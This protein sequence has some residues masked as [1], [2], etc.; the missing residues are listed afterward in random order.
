MHSDNCL[1]EECQPLIVSVRTLVEF[2]LR[3]GDLTPGGFQKRDRAQLGTQGHQSVQRSRPEGYESEV[4]IAYRVE[5][6]DLPVEVRGR[7]DGLYASNDPVI[8]EEIKTTTLS[9]ELISEQHNPLHWAQ[10][11]CYAYMVARQ[12]QLSEVRVHLTYYHLDSR[13]EKTFERQYPLAE[14]QSFFFDLITPYLDWLRKVQAWQ[15]RRDRSIQQ[16]E[17]PYAEYRAG[18]RDMAV[19]VYKAVRSHERLYIQSPTGVGKTMAAL[20]PA[21][22]ALGQGLAGKIF[23]LTAKTSGRSVAEKGLDDLRQANLYLR[24]VTLTAKEKICFCPPVTCDPEVCPFAR[25]YFGKVKRALLETADVQAFTRPVIEEIARQYQICPFEFSLDLA[26]WADCVICDYNYAFDPRV[27]LHRFFDNNTEPYIFLVD[28]A[29]NLPDRARSMYSAELDKK[30]V[31]DLQRTLKSQLPV[32]AQ[33]LSAINKIL[34]E[35]RKTCQAQDKPALVEHEPPKELIKAIREFSQTAEDWLVLNQ[36][37]A[38]RQ[39]LIEFY[40]LCSHYLRTA[41]YFDRFYV[42]Y[43]ERQGSSDLKAKIFCLDPAPMLA[44][45]LERSQAAIFFSATLLPM[46]YFTKLLTGA[47]VHPKRTFPSPFPTENVS[48]LIHNG[49]TTK[50]AQRADSYAAIANAIEV[51][52]STHVGN[53]LVFFPSYA[54]LSAVLELLKERLPEKQLLVQDRSMP[55]AER[56][57]FLAQFSAGNHETLIGFAVMGGIFGEGIDL[58]GERLIGAVVV[59]V[60]VPQVCLENDLIKEYF[61]RQNGNGFAYAYQYPGF[62]R[63][64]QATGRVIRTE[65]D[66]GIIVLIDERFSQA[67]YR[68]LFP[69]HW[70]NFQIVQNTSEINEKLTRFWSP[71]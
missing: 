2:V 29:H 59:G 35:M 10:A 63:V 67:R 9:L 25:D 21:L 45:P 37:A 4:E 3:A 12:Y 64:L 68:H 61:D 11:Q 27:Y 47:A 53:Y 30:T 42:S 15:D 57:A 28:E 23:Y 44:A 48:L 17:F 19:A 34:L 16:L 60:G 38:F 6:V 46:D 65:T 31:L 49:I 33:K 8:I 39:D 20:F 13:K 58:V 14:L 7:M 24:S 52:C 22:K 36:A 71:G 43:F 18:Q 5:G 26:L 70:R 56:E 50:Y 41:E 55:E 54:Y 62:N 40:F 66:R 51:I 69:A 1:S 32:L